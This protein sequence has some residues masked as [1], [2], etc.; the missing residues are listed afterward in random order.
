VATRDIWPPGARAG[1]AGRPGGFTPTRFHSHGELVFQDVHEASKAIVVELGDQ[2]YARLV[3]EVDDPGREIARIT[4]AAGAVRGR[5]FGAA[6]VLATPRPPSW[7]RTQ[8]ARADDD[9][10]ILGTAGLLPHGQF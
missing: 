7:G 2:R 6:A 4:E 3:I 5:T 9:P 10:R 1:G 8:A